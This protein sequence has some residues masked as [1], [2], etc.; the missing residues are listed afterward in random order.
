MMI[1]L[2]LCIAKVIY[3]TSFGDVNIVKINLIVQTLV[4]L[5]TES[6]MRNLRNYINYTTNEFKF[7]SGKNTTI[8]ALFDAKNVKA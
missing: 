4:F 7:N 1:C 8:V 5:T 3:I 2:L 6:Y